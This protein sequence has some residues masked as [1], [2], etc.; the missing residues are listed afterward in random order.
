MSYFITLIA[1][2]CFPAASSPEDLSDTVKKRIAEFHL[3]NYQEYQYHNKIMRVCEGLFNGTVGKELKQRNS[4]PIYEN[5]LRRIH[6][7]AN[8]RQRKLL[9]TL[10]ALARYMD[11]GGWI[12]KKTAKEISEVFKLANVTLSSDKRNELLH[13]LYAGGHI[14]FGKKVDN[15]NIKVC[16]EESGEIGY[17]LQEFQN[18]GYQYIGNFKTGYKQCVCCGKAYKIKSA[19]DFSSKYCDSCSRQKRLERSKNSMRKLRENKKC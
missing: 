8:D 7:L 3:E 10:F 17:Q 4:V 5:E 13:E 12:N 18:L 16:L 9:F 14:A 11:C 1:K 6:S 2:Y 19:M 15:L